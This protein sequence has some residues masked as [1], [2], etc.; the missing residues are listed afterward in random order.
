MGLILPNLRDID[1]ESKLTK[2]ISQ[3]LNNDFQSLYYKFSVD[4]AKSSIEFYNTK[5]MPKINEMLHQVL[6][7]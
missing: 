2:T 7:I 4:L 6:Q 3:T 5:D 1:L